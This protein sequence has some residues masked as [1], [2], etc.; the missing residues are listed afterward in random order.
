ML[1]RGKCFLILA[2]DLHN[3]PLKMQVDSLITEPRIEKAAESTVTDNVQNLASTFGADKLAEY[4]ELIMDWA[5]V[6][7]PKLLVAGLI[8]WIG[9]KV[10]GKLSEIVQNGISK[11]GIDPEIS[12]FLGSII[13]VI[14]KFVVVM[15]AAGTLGF[16]VSSL[17]SLVAA[18]M[19]AIGLALQG[20]LGNFASGITIVFL[21][22]YKV[23]DWVEVAE[24]FGRVKD[25]QIFNTIVE[26][27]GSKTLVIPNGQV[28]DNII[29]NFS[30]IGKVRL[31]LEILVGYE[32]S[33]P[34][35]KKVILE[36]LKG[37]DI[38]MHEPIMVGIDSYDTHN[39]ILAVRPYVHPDDYWDAVYGCHER[40]K[41]AFNENGVKMAYSE[42]VE[43]GP[44]GA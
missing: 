25:I 2:F 19:V 39:I 33:F 11:T 20:F 34:K 9:M 1:F 15:A 21:K 7:V 29:T 5:V 28:T 43:L 35:L 44:I 17:L 23:G 16:Q 41:A 8:L 42:G 36:A 10:V 32:E 38:L 18:S 6:F 37:Y 4:G 26:T 13:S 12:G 40:I 22:P 24:K 30:T 27:P 3:P 31:E 14:M